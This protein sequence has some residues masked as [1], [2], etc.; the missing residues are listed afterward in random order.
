MGIA[1]L[2]A[3]ILTASGG[4]YLLVVWLIEND[5]ANQGAAASRLPGLTVTSHLLLALGGLAIWVAHLITGSQALAWWASAFLVVVA[6]LGVTMLARWIPVYRAP[7]PAVPVSP[8]PISAVPVPQYPAPGVPAERNFPLA[9]V[10]AHGV[11]GASALLLVLLA[12][13]QAG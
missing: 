3:W 12:T 5:G 13:L 11:L 8:A 6:G 1:A 4:L 2:T 9:V 10:L 7:V